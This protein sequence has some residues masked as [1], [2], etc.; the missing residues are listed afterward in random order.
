MY[1]FTSSVFFALGLLCAAAGASSS[2]SASPPVIPV[3]TPSLA[4]VPA[5]VRAKVDDARRDLEVRR[6]DGGPVA[7]A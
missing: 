6:A 3:P 7:E 4:G 2:E 5:E 1:R